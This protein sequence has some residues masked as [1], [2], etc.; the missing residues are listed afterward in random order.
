MFCFVLGGVLFCFVLVVVAVVLVCLF[1]LLSVV[2]ITVLLINH[3]ISLVV[4]LSIYNKQETY[5]DDKPERNSS[6]FSFDEKTFSLT[7]VSLKFIVHVLQPMGS[8]SIYFSCDQ[9]K[10]FCAVVNLRALEIGK[11]SCC[12]K[13]VLN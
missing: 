12:F 9:T 2:L 13:F 5:L 4:N 11:L 1:L 3:G 10:L 8:F 7:L 6:S